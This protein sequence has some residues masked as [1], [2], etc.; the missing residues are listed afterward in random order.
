MF[1]LLLVFTQPAMAAKTFVY[2]SEGSPSSFGPSLVADSASGNNTD[3]MHDCLVDFERGTTKVIPSLAEKWEVSKDGLSYTFHLRKDVSF[4]TTAYFTPT[5]NFNADDVLFTFNRQR[6][7][8]HPFHQI[9]AAKYEVFE[10]L[11]LPETI[12]DIVKLDD[13]TVQFVLN[14]P[15][16]AFLADM[17]IYFSGII[18]KE[19]GDQLLKKGTPEK[20]DLEPVG[21]GAYSFVKYE[22]DQTVRYKANPKYFRGKP[23]V[24]NLIFSITPDASVRYQKLK[25]GECHFIAEPGLADLAAMKAD[26]ALKTTELQ[27][28]NIGYLALNVTKKPL[29]NPVVRK[30]IY[31][32]LNRKSYIEAVYLGHAALNP[33]PLPLLQ[34]GFN[35]KIKDYEYSVEK[36]K[37][38]LKQ[39]GLEKGFAMDMWTLPVSRAYNPNGKRMGEMM[40]SDLAKIGI[41]V[42]LNSLDWPSYLVKAKTSDFMS[43]QFGWNGDN[44]DPDNFLYFL[45]S[46]ASVTQGSNHA[47]WC[48]KPYDDL[49]TKAKTL[50]SQAARTK[51]YEQAQAIFHDQVPFIPLATSY[52]YRAMSKRVTGYKMAAVGVNDYFDNID[53]E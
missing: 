21:T 13:Y 42:T 41:T 28:L 48:F 2:C 6:V 19:Y 50:T 7:K 4:H 35:K 27:M 16:A 40:Q 20:I 5:R 34:W 33:N 32:A 29:D 17:G 46:C 43:I 49:V 39:A 26:S 18:S 3:Q 30:A 31:H 47:H 25:S 44:G 24:D 14:R 11:G 51:L 38:L 53:L 9:G 45:L 12:K 8:D 37:A 1:L 23:K 22:K 52:S 10:S 15:D 36:A